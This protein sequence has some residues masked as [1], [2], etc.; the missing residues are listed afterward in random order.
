ML[1]MM[2]LEGGQVVICIGW[3]LFNRLYLDVNGLYVFIQFLGGYFG[4]CLME[5][6]CEDKGYIYN[7]LVVYDM[8][9]FDGI[10]QIDMEVS[11][12]YVDVMLM[13]VQ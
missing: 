2:Y 6:I 8:F 9:C 10:F 3:C 5:N 13:E 11:I 4:S 7:I 12:E 1:C